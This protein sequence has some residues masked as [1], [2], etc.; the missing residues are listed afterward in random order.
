MNQRPQTPSKERMHRSLVPMLV[1]AGCGAGTTP[2]PIAPSLDPAPAWTP[3]RTLVLAQ[4][5]TGSTL[6]ADGVVG[7]GGCQGGGVAGEYSDNLF[8]F[9]PPATATYRFHVNAGYDAVLEIEAPRTARGHRTSLGCNGMKSKESRSFDLVTTLR[10]N[11]PYVV[12]VNGRMQ[13]R[14]EY[15]LHV[16]TDHSKEAAI[17]PEDPAI[18]EGLVA[19]AAPLP[20]GQTLGDFAS[21]VGG[22]R[23]ACGGLGSGT[24]HTLVVDQARPSLRV[25]AATQF[26]SALELRTA[27]GVAVTC[28]RSRA[29]SFE[30]EIARRLVPGSYVVVLD[31]T[32][33]APVGARDPIR[34]A[35][36][37]GPGIHAAYVIDV[38][39]SP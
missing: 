15:R 18:V 26:P 6:R 34:D 37:P 27:A 9:T 17:A 25:R 14:G 19:S 38:E 10:A 36:D 3:S 1:L 4:E 5:V 23:A 8:T 24:V 2:A 32:D 33:I 31:T 21:R 11:E 7:F 22:A 29:G 20:T 30:V 39:A 12:I 28:A 16:T 13:A 35:P